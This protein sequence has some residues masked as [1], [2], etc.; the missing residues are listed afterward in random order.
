MQLAPAT[1]A[2]RPTTP[3]ASG[4][5]PSFT[6]GIDY[7]GTKGRFTKFSAHATDFVYGDPKGYDTLDAAIDAATF[8]TI[9]SRQA[10]AGIF[11]LDGRFHARRLDNTLT[12]KNGATW[13]GVWRLEQY[14]ADRELLDGTIPGVTRADALKAVVDGAQRIDVTNLPVA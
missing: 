1:L 3:P 11:E 2:M 14:P 12:F 13:E 8:A 10:A 9:G 4:E 5:V 7:E 6:G